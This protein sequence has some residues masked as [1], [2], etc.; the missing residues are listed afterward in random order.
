MWGK[1]SFLKPGIVR[2]KNM[3]IQL[4]KYAK[5]L[6]NKEVQSELLLAMGKPY[7]W[8][9]YY[10]SK[11]VITN[12]DGTNH[13]SFNIVNDDMLEWMKKIGNFNDAS[14]I[15]IGRKADRKD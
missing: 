9:V 15:C 12:N 7:K 5:E 13:C 10:G 1:K 2:D 11:V 6:G 3:R 4:M 14:E 8:Q